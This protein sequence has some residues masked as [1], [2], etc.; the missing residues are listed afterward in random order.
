M[1]KRA[2]QAVGHHRIDDRPVTDAV[3]GAGLGEQVGGIGH[4]L[5]ATSHHG[6]GFAEADHLGGQV[7]GMQPRQAGP[8]QQRAGHGEG[9]PRIGDG[10]TGRH[11]A[12]TGGHN[13]AQ[14]GEVDVLGSDSRAI[15][16]RRDGS[17]AQISR[18][19]RRQAALESTHGGTGPGEYDDGRT[20]LGAGHSPTVP[21][22]GRP[23]RFRPHPQPHFPLVPGP[24]R[25]RRTGRRRRVTHCGGPVRRSFLRRG[26][27]SRRR[28]PP[29]TAGGR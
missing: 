5:H 24:P 23:V 10:P 11:L 15:D 17:G 16:G 14:V 18:C 19:Q 4:G 8:V 28:R 1:L 21:V 27:R 26:P 12:D 20:G 22:R 6:V 29:W 13:V 2:G 3:A 9:N 25:V 7:D